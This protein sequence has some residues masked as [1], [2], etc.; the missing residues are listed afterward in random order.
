MVAS[1]TTFIPADRLNE[2]NSPKYA[3]QVHVNPLT[4]DWYMALNTRTPPFNNLKAR[5]AINY[6][7]DRSAYVK[8]AGGPSLA[9]PTC[10]VL[11]PNFPSYSPYCPYTAGSSHTKWTGPDV[12]K[13]KQLVQQSHTAGMKVVVDSTNDQVGKAFAEQMVSDLN[14]IG[15]KASPQLLAASIQYP[16]VQNSSNSGKWNVGYSAWY[17][18][19]PAA[20]D[21]LNVLLGC[22]TIH[23]NSDA[24]PNIAAFCD[25]AVQAKINQAENE[26]ATNPSGAAAL[27][28]QV[29]HADTNAAP[30]VDMFNPKQ[31]DVLSHNVH[32]YSWSPQ[33]YILIDRLWLS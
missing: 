11:P 16:F 23:P 20:S 9:V 24:S 30:W 18:D 33:W 1:T 25:Q 3:K 14:A 2:L 26:G 7:A 19:Y 13:A 8:I 12:A 21:F 4:A 15:Y 28:T 32:G 10:Q 5:Q 29:D 22:G 6:A 27:W 17:Q 31:I